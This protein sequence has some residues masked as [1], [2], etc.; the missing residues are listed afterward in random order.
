MNT[1]G[2]PW[3]PMD[4]YGYPWVPMNIYG[5]PWISIDTHGYLCTYMKISHRIF[6][7]MDNF[8]GQI[9]YKKLKQ[10]FDVQ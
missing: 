5:Y 3:L 6:H 2:Y 10:A 7:I 4:T 1:Y 9:L 8:F